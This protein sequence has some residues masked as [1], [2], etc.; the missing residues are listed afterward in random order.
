MKRDKTDRRTDQQMDMHLFKKVRFWHSSLC[1]TIQ[2]IFN[3]DITISSSS[4][5]CSKRSC[6]SSCSGWCNKVVVILLVFFLN[7][8]EYYI[9]YSDRSFHL[10]LFNGY[11]HVRIYV[12]LFSFLLIEKW[13]AL[14]IA[15]RCINCFAKRQKSASV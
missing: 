2:R 15:M 8:T 14:F 1:D 9:I 10:F 3:N 13:Y 12:L 4:R 7:Y 6:S 5:N 11:S